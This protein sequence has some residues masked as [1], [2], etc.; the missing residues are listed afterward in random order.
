M[1]VFFDVEFVSYFFNLNASVSAVATISTVFKE[2]NT[3]TWRLNATLPQPIMPI[4]SVFVI[5]T[6]SPLERIPVNHFFA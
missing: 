6:I 2:F 3:G 1:K 5:A 4:F